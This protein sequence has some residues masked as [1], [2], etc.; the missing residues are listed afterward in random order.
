MVALILQL[1]LFPQSNAI[2]MFLAS[3]MPGV[4]LHVKLALVTQ[5]IAGPAF[6]AFVPMTVEFVTDTTVDGHMRCYSVCFL[7]QCVATAET[8]STI[9]TIPHPVFLCFLSSLMDGS[10]VLPEASELLLELVNLS[11]VDIL[12][13]FSPSVTQE[14]MYSQSTSPVFTSAYQTLKGLLTTK[15]QGLWS[16]QA[17]EDGV[18]VWYCKKSCSKSLLN[19]LRLVDFSAQQ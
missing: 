12:I 9:V 13:H 18:D 19:S 10:N 16:K 4:L 7:R 8:A 17:Q 2:Q 1:F 5:E 14:I 3:E 11:D 15:E 6:H